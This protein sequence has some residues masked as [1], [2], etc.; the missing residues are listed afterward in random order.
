MLKNK[1]GHAKYYFLSSVFA[2]FTVSLCLYLF[3]S[4]LEKYKGESGSMLLHS[5]VSS[6]RIL[7]RLLTIYRKCVMSKN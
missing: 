3:P 4:F 1:V 2:L 5:S 6:N 7:H